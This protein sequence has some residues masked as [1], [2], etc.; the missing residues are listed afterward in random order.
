[1]T[2]TSPMLEVKEA[3]LHEVQRAA[4]RGGAPL[5]LV[6]PVARTGPVV[7]VKEA[8]L[9]EVQRA[10]HE[11]QRA[12]RQRPARLGGPG[13]EDRSRGGVEGGPPP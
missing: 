13:G 11:V 8:C 5:N 12:A 9:H 7:E 10:A 3:R 2:K 4:R 6:V 1:M